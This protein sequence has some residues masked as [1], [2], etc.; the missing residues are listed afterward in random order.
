MS[1][2]L[3]DPVHQLGELIN[4]ALK[5]HEQSIFLGYV[6]FDPY[7]STACVLL[8]IFPYFPYIC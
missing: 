6:S 1:M 7:G 2:A 3:N 5:N 8:I 4:H